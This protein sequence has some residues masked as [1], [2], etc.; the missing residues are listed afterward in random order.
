MAINKAFGADVDYATL[1]KLY[2]KP[3]RRDLFAIVRRKLSALKGKKVKCGSPEPRYLYHIIHRTPEFD[4][5]NGNAAFYA[6]D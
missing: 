5:E 2:S 6:V 3:A 4:D 1:I